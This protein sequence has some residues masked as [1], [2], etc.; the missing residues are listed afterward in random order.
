MVTIE[1][2]RK[3]IDYEKFWI[4]RLEKRICDYRKESDKMIRYINKEYYFKCIKSVY[5]K[6]CRVN[7]LLIRLHWT[8][9]IVRE[10]IR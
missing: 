1:Q 3:K 9:T 10:M 6:K 7:R 2:L 8:K 5:K 4:K